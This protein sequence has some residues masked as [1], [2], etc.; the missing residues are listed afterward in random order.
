MKLLIG[1]YVGWSLETGDEM[2]IPALRHERRVDSARAGS[3]IGWG[4]LQV[5]KPRILPVSPGSV[6]G[7]LAQNETPESMIRTLPG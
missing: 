4:F 3:I 5:G 6:N 2:E 7:D 1:G